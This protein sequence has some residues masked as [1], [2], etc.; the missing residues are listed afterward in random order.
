MGSS[1]RSKLAGIVLFTLTAVVVLGGMAWATAASVELARRNL[2]FAHQSKVARALG[3]LESNI[4]WFL[5]SESNRPYTDYVDY[6]DVE[7][8]AVLNEDGDELDV[9]RVLVRSTLAESELP[10]DWIDLY[11]QVDHHG[12]LTSPQFEEEGWSWSGDGAGAPLDTE[13][14][15]R[16]AWKWLRGV[17]P[18]V[19]LRKRLTEAR[20]EAADSMRSRFSLALRSSDPFRWPNLAGLL[21]SR[22]SD[23]PGALTPPALPAELPRK[24]APKDQCIESV[25]Y[26]VKEFAPP[27]WLEDGQNS[28]RRLAFVRECHRDASVL[29]QGFIGDWD[30]LKPILLGLVK[31]WLPDADLEP[32]LAHNSPDEEN[33]DLKLRNFPAVMMVPDIAVAVNAAA[34]KSVRGVLLITW[35]AA[36]AV[37]AVA[38]WGLKSLVALTE[39]RLQFAYAVTHEL[40]TP[41]TTLRLYS[42][43]LAAGM[44]PETSRQEYLD[45]LNRE[46]QR[47]SS[48]VEGVLEYARLEHHQARLHVKDT[49]GASLLGAIRETLEARCREAGVEA[50]AESSVPT[51]RHLV[52]DIDLVNQI[53]GVL[54]HNACRH[55][56]TSPRPVVKLLLG[57]ENG[58]LHVDVIDSGPGVPRIDSRRIFKPFRRGIDA[59]VAA[60]GGIGLGLALA[61][62]WAE[63]LGGR[64]DL[65]ARHDPQLGGAHFRLTIPAQSTN[66]A[67]S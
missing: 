48:L 8:L 6:H 17:L 14:R 47:L 11:F 52:T 65:V 5:N 54:I 55:A 3:E 18:Q 63:L 37:L 49:D 23:L 67:A 21:P 50:R 24:Y 10:H 31:E 44:I 57:G 22:K 19:D 58:K 43:L 32:V 40:R 15:A 16:F 30:R 25:Q 56:K 7:P 4:T 13:I 46:S 12:L 9:D 59:D 60:R 62:S 53:T 29:Y 1:R 28:I 42:D 51:R 34:W 36:V 26:S 64:L 33:D 38:G 61:R 66:G 39:R 41:L 20:R 45:T 27:F 2:L 35:S